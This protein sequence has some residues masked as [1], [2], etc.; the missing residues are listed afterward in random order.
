MSEVYRVIDDQL[1]AY[2]TR[3]VCWQ[4]VQALCVKDSGVIRQHDMNRN[5]AFQLFGF[6]RG[7]AWERADRNTDD[8]DGRGA[9]MEGQSGR[10]GEVPSFVG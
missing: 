3:G 6:H 10:A 4:W 9:K 7:C 8:A 2:S 5:T 1:I